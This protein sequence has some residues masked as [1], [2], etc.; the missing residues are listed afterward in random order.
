M[1]NRSTLITIV[2]T[3]QAV[4]MGIKSLRIT[5]METLNETP[6]Q[7]DGPPLLSSTA[8]IT[9]T[10][11]LFFIDGLVFMKLLIPKQPFRFITDQTGPPFGKT[12]HG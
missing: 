4:G 5:L 8:A 1:A 6:T 12:L 3:H 10:L 2:I 9:K 7:Q 11:N